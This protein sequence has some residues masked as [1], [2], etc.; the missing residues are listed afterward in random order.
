MIVELKDD[1][2]DTSYDAA[3]LSTYSN[4]K[5]ITLSYTSIFDILWK[6]NELY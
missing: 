4:S 1:T 6:Q 2:R 5:S 3:G